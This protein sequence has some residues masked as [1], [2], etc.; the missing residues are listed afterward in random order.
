MIHS[1]SSLDRTKTTPREAMHIVALALKAAGVDIDT[2]SLST[3]SMYRARKTVCRLQL[4]V[5]GP[6]AAA[7]CYIVRFRHCFFHH[8]PYVFTLVSYYHKTSAIIFMH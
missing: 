4:Q 6:V 3:S 7:Q 5:G 1:V 8:I 2:L